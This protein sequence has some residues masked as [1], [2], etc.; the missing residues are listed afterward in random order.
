MLNWT[1]SEE[2]F[3]HCIKSQ[4]VKVILTAKS[5]FQKVQ[6]PWLQKYKMTFF[7]DILKDISLMQK[8]TAV[9]KAMRFKIPTDIS[10]IAVVLFTS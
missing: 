7:E 9:C 2:A 4:N 5:F 1:Q 6:T 8:L 3:A 10:K